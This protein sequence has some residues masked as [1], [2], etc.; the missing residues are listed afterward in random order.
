MLELPRFLAKEPKKWFNVL[1]SHVVTWKQFCDLFRKVF[2]PS[3]NQERILRGILDRAQT[4][5]ELLP[6]FVAHM[7]SEFKKLTT[8][9]PQLEQIELIY[10]HAVEK[11]RVA[12]Y[13][14]KVTSVMD[15]LLR[16]HELHAVLGPCER[17]ATQ[18]LQ[19]DHATKAVHCFKCLTPG[20]TS[21][22][23]PTCRPQNHLNAPS[24][25]ALNQQIEQLVEAQSSE[26]PGGVPPTDGV[27]PSASVRPRSENFRGGGRFREAT[28]PR[29]HN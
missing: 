11:Y 7:L 12:L 3:D 2:L 4:P 27:G 28:L 16:A 10:N 9:P 22:T 6:T 24:A 14:T 29:D 8:P 1:A 19:T 13:G 23:C 26:Q 20:F 5:D 25:G 17:A 18:L 15:L 21:R